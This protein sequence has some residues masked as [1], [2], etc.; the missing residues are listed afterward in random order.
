MITLT[1]VY[2]VKFIARKQWFIS[3]SAEGLIHVYSYETKMQKVK[4][5]RA[6]DGVK[7]SLAV[8]PTLPY[9]LSSPCSGPTRRSY[10]T[11][12]RDG[13]AHKHLRG[14]TLQGILYVKSLLTQRRPTDLLALRT[15]LL[16]Y[17]IFLLC[18]N[19]FYKM[20]ATSFD[21]NN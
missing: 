4:S 10:G 8:H 3:S 2:S 21:N 14:S 19:N 20:K 9:V 11:G 13:T 5:F 18:R 15:I 12:K 7:I 1:A 16:R 6:H 17:C